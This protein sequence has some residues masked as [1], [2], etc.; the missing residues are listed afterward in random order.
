L[1]DILLAQNNVS[2]TDF[3]NSLLSAL[4]GAQGGNV[5]VRQLFQNFPS[6][7]GVD[8]LV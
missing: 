6:G 3:Q 1:L 8:A 7:Q 2:P 4:T 5:D